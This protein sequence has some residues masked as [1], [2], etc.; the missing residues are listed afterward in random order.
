ML[1]TEEIME[2]CFGSPREGMTIKELTEDIR[3]YVEAYD[4]VSFSEL[5]R[6]Y[7]DQGKGESALTLAADENIVLWLGLSAP[8]VDALK[9]LL[10]SG[11]VQLC[12]GNLFTYLLD[13]KMLLMPLAKRL[14][15]GGYR[16]P[17]WL[18]VLLRPGGK[19]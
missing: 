14:P 18:P 11:A 9:H 12:P 17:H 1:S 10:E 2:M 6:R 8:L 3:K 4:Y 7:G 19:R 15:R 5:E 13:Q 16:R